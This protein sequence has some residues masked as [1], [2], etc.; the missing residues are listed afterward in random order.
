MATVQLNCRV[1]ASIAKRL[2]LEA[3]ARH[4]TTGSLITQAIELLLASPSGTV[5]TGGLA[6]LEARVAKLEAA[7]SPKW[8]MAPSPI[9]VAPEPP[10]QGKV[11][12]PK[13]LAMVE[14]GTGVSTP[15]LAQIL[16]INR[17]TI[18]ERIRRKGGAAVGFEMAGWRIIGKA[19]T[20]AGGPAQ[21]RWEQV[22]AD[23][24]LDAVKS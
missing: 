2:R 8:G 15:E 19:S 12:P 1:E 14:A 22:V 23:V 18:N 6:A 21:W 4:T 16:G 3:Q 17:G 10:M 7:T 13:Q 9:T 11:P 24:I 5:A 20:L